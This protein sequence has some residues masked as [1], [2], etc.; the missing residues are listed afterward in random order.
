MRREGT[1]A[2]GKIKNNH[3]SREGTMKKRFPLL[4]FIVAL[5]AFIY[6]LGSAPQ[7]L[8]LISL[9]NGDLRLDGFVKNYTYIRTHIPRAEGQFHNTPCR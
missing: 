6:C 8:A 7:A 1:A 5:A 9:M 4:T 3:I 2:K